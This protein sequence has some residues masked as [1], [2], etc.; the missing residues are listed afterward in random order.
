MSETEVNNFYVVISLL[1]YLNL[2][3]HLEFWVESLV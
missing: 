3:F 2:L 1:F